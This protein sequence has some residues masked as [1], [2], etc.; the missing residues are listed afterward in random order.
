[1]EQLTEFRQLLI[2]SLNQFVQNVGAYLPNV[3]GAIVVL[4]AGLLLAWT[5]KWLIL[6]LGTGFDRILQSLGMASVNARLR[7]PLANII[8]WIFYG[9]IIL[10]SLRAALASLKLPSLAELLGRLITSLPT[11]L[12]AVI[13]IFAGVMFGNALKDRIYSGARTIGLQQAELLG[14][15][16][17]IIV[18]T[19]AVI[20]GLTQ[21]GLDVR[22][23][24]YILVIIVAAAVGAIG[25]AFGLG[26]GPTVSNIISTRYIR[27]NYQV[28]Q[29][30][31]IN[32]ME[33]RILEILPTGIVLE[34]DTG[35]T[36]IPGKIFDEQAS[37]LM[38]DKSFDDD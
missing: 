23:F 28:N 35:R 11:L 3:F 30:I 12:I 36:F 16:T 14:Q 31:R 9:I 22:L 32:D 18:I 15:L 5:V 26:A 33:G 19:L 21:I 13:V 7:W 27:K 10:I 24:E 2:D 17:R 6:K 8:G 34:T 25:L 4:F 20:V 37:V 29:E 1:M 38:D